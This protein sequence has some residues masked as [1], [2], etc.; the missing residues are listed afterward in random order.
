MDADSWQELC[1]IPFPPPNPQSNPTVCTTFAFDGAQELLWTGNEFGRVSSLYGPNLQRYTSY[2]GHD[3]QAEAVKQT[4]PCDKGVLSVGARSVHLSERRGRTLWH[5]THE[6][7]VDLRCC[8]IVG[9]GSAELLVAGCQSTM[10]KVDIDKGQVL[11]TL[12]SR[13][14]YT[15]M[16][17]G[18]QFICAGTSTGSVQLLNFKTFE[19]VKSWKA[20]QGWINDIDANSNFL[21]T[22]GWSPRQHHGA[23]PDPLARVFDLKTLMPLPPVT[24][25]AGASFVRMHPRMLTTCIIASRGG[26]LQ[27]V[28]IMN[29]AMVNVR[30]IP[31]LVDAALTGMD[32]APSGEALVLSDTT[33]SLQLLGSHSQVRFSNHSEPTEFADAPTIPRPSMSWDA[34]EPL[35]TIGMPYYR[36]VLLSAWPSHMIFEVGAPPAGIDPAILSNLT[37]T[38]TQ[39]NDTLSHAV[40]PKKTRRNAAVNTRSQ[41]LIDSE[42]PGPRFLSEQAKDGEDLLAQ[43]RMS[44]I[45]NSMDS[46][47]ILSKTDIPAMYRSVEIKY[48]RFGV[49]DF[50]FEY[51]NKTIF[52][53]LET[54]I[55]NSYANSLLQLL[56]FTPLIRNLAL[57]HTSGSCVYETCLLCEMGYLID[58]LEKAGGQNCQATNF[59]KAFGSASS[60]SSLGLLEDGAM[61]R[62]LTLTIQ[63]ACRYLLDKVTADFRQTAPQLAGMDQALNTT[64]VVNMVC[65]NCG[66]QTM[67]PSG[68]LTHDLVY[69]SRPTSKYHGR[70][71]SVFFSSVL[72]SSVERQEQTRGWCDRCKRYQQLSSQKR[73]QGVAPV[74]VIN[75]AAHTPEARQLWAKPNWLPREI[76]IIVEQGHFFCYEGRDLQHHLQRGAY[77]MAVYELIGVVADVSSEE[78]PKSHLVSMINVAPSQPEQTPDQWHIF[79]DFLVRAIPTEEALRFDPAW[80]LPS[81]LTYQLK[82]HRHSVDDSWK[83]N[84]DTSLLYQTFSAGAS[85]D[86]PAV[87]RTLSYPNEVPQPGSAIGLDAEF[88]ALQQE[89]IEVKAD[90]SRSTLRPSRLAL[91]RVSALR[92]GSTVDDGTPEAS[93]TDEPRYVPFIDDYIHI[94][95]PIVDYLTAY[96]GINPGDL[97]LRSSPHLSRGRLVP[98][99]TAYKKL[100]LLLNLGC[101]FVGHGLPKD[102]RTI[103]IHIPRAQVVDTVDLFFDKRRQ[104]KLSL[105]FLSWFLLGERVQLEGGDRGHDSVE[106]A[107]MA[108]R[109]WEHWRVLEREGRTKETIDRIY[110]RGRELGF[111]VP[112]VDEPSALRESLFPSAGAAEGSRPTSSAAVAGSDTPT[113]RVTPSLSEGLPSAGP[114]PVKGSAAV[115]IRPATDGL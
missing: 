7:F 106:D 20:H 43:R 87:F 112:S 61:S 6:G 81:V 11:E 75:A 39:G 78:H 31:L 58:M 1:R 65:T 13:D 32:I 17:R 98:L 53:G 25:H 55:P 29:A 8:C 48:S 38:R 33:C 18:G 70:S 71:P 44:D 22:C 63:A 76:G 30:Q 50:D 94:H 72:K 34:D 52:S 57:Q 56:R 95:E 15:H 79:N 111:R 90:G 89:E 93:G 62:P 54:H 92:G 46:Q 74:L 64:S 42:L 59:L 4:L 24:F 86:D 10:F 96:S 41:D 45:I 3:M 102:F 109:L 103:N 105:R 69:P 19:L 80:K 40:N 101:V 47:S 36:E 49:E 83:R 60:S 77:K 5:L 9:K 2:R 82:S 37:H 85:P 68:T 73:I 91:A 66:T 115:R 88:V 28:D 21:L 67:R 113:G 84:L 26:Q 99:K 27:M 97:S 114:T 23:M 51:Y 35:N 104:R 107:R 14:H 12:Q 16:K 110:Q 100:W 108:V